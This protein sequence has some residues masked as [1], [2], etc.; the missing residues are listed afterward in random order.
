MPKS[1]AF[2]NGNVLV[3]TDAYG[4]VRDVYFPFVG[5]ENHIGGAYAHKI[6]VWVEQFSW[7]D[8]GHGN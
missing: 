1:L 3:C 4:R 5:L 6:G 2:G 8:D 7:L